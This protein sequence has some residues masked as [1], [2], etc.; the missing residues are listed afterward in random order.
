MS[1][2]RTKTPDPEIPTAS[3]PVEAAKPSEAINDLFHQAMLD[4]EKALEAGIQLQ[5]QSVKFWEDILAQTG[6]M[7]ALQTKLESL[8]AE[9]FPRARK[10]LEDCIEAVSMNLMLANRASD[11]ALDLFSRAASV[12]QSTSISEAQ[13]RLQSLI[14]HSITA[15]HNDVQRVLNTNARVFGWWAE[16]A[17]LNPIAML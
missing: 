7:E 13:G 3:K 1:A 12:L 16:M 17:S 2:K 15:T 10:G 4:Y 14:D 5:E 11:Q 8:S 9:V 6:S